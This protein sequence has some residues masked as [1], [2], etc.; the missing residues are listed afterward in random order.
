MV[1]KFTLGNIGARDPVSVIEEK[2]RNACLPFGNVVRFRLI[3]DDRRSPVSGLA[4]VGFE[5]HEQRDR[6]VS[7]TG[8]A[9]VEEGALISFR[10][11]AC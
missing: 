8:A 10:G 2:I 9:L 4:V 7:S 5:R 1:A 3:I 6:F 11:Q